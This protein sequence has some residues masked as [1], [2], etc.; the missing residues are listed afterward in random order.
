M[1]IAGISW[2]LYSL[3]GRGAID[4]LTY[5]AHTFLSEAVGP[6]YSARFVSAAPLIVEY[7]DT[8]LPEELEH[9]RT[10]VR[11][12]PAL[13]ELYPALKELAAS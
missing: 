5:E 9:Y 7:M 12:S 10:A 6:E 3:R 13:T 8:R 1:A 2:G 11:L 4:S